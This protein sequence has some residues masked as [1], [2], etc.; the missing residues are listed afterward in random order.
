VLAASRAKA[1]AT[2][3]IGTGYE[4][5]ILEL[6]ELMSA[7]TSFAGQLVFTHARAGDVR[8]SALDP[9][10]A[11]AALGWRASVDLRAGIDRTLAWYRNAAG[12][13]STPSS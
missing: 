1:G 12:R 3:N 5:S 4:T 11:G 7:S 8:R 13:R 9:A 10:A 2:V 6:F